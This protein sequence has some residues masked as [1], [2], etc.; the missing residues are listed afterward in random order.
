M[1]KIYDL[2]IPTDDSRSKPQPVKVE[3][4]AQRVARGLPL[5]FATVNGRP[6][7]TLALSIWHLLPQFCAI[8]TAPLA[9]RSIVLELRGTLG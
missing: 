8:F 2:S 6:L 4:K 3:H 9:S 1:I 7:A 5:T